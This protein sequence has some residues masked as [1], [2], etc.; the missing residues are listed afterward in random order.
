VHGA[1]PADGD[2]AERAGQVGLAHADWS[3]DEG[4]VRAVGEFT[5]ASAS[6]RPYWPPLPPLPSWPR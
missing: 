4:A 1:A 5:S 2:V 6:P 3:Q